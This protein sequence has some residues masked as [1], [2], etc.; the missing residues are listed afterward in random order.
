MV[1]LF[2]GMPGTGKTSMIAYL[3]HD[4]KFRKKYKNIYSNVR[5]ND[6]D[7]TFVK[8]DYIGKYM[9]T[10]GALLIDEASIFADSRDYKNFSKSLKEFVYLHRH[11]GIDIFLWAQRY[12]AVDKTLRELCDGGVWYMYKPLLTGWY[13]TKYYRIPYGI[14][15]PDAKKNKERTGNT[16]GE[17]EEGYCKPS[18]ITRLL[19]TKSFNRRK[20]YGYF[21][22]WEAPELPPIPGK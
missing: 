14:V 5:M 6:T 19:F 17:I 21:D 3:S 13:K 20:T 15:I 12:S 1:T 10:D 18:L 2:F 11:Y 16:L 8:N 7:Y 9:I 22:S 4:K